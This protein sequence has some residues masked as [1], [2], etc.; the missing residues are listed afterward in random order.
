MNRKRGRKGG[1]SV[2]E[3]GEGGREGRV[4][5]RLEREEGRGESV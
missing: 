4:C 5:V 2:C 1:E 3:V